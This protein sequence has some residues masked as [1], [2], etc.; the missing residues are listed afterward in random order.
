M[1]RLR[2]LGLALGEGPYEKSG[3]WRGRKYRFSN[4]GPASYMGRFGGGWDRELGV[5]VGRN[6]VLINLWKSSIR[7][8]K[9]RSK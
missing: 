5:Q 6:T 2:V 1:K 3:T 8:D 9:K 4:R 7:I